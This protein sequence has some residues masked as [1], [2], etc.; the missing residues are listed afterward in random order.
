MKKKLIKKI[1]NGDLF[2]DDISVEEFE[3]KLKM[4]KNNYPTLINW[5]FEIE[6]GWDSR[7]ILLV[8]DRLETDEEYE[9]RMKN[10][11]YF[12]ETVRITELKELQR[13]KEKYEK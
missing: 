8:G 2:Y 13:L 4:F 10:D 3:V 1:I 9:K 12:E 11:A 5:R 7:D 6:Y